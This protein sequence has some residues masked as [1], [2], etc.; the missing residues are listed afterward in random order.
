MKAVQARAEA[1]PFSDGVFERVIVVDALHHFSSRQTALDE[2]TRI[3]SPGGRLLIEE[4]DLK[5]L[6]VKIV[7]VLEKILMMESH[8]G[9]RRHCASITS[10]GPFRLAH[11]PR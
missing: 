8:C 4:P 2:L 6:G 1:L 3:L 5:R 10:E 7:A 11:P 9:T